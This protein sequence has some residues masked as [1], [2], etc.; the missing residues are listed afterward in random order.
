MTREIRD[1]SALPRVEPP[2]ATLRLPQGAR[3]LLQRAPGRV[4]LHVSCM[5]VSMRAARLRDV[6]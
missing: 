1:S 3:I 5:C 4:H 2:A 6:L